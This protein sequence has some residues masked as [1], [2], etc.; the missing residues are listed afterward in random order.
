MCEIG[1]WLGGGGGVGEKSVFLETTC[2]FPYDR[3]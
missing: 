2:L 1:I 3:S